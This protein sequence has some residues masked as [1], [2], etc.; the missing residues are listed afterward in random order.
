MQLSFL[1]VLSIYPVLEDRS[2]P[3][4][5]IW[6]KISIKKSE[7]FYKTTFLHCKGRSEIQST[8]KMTAAIDKQLYFITFR[9]EIGTDSF[10]TNL[11]FMKSFSYS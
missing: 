4:R 10:L 11:T 1:K 3:K 7:H 8:E 2:H 5:Q 6:R 9:V